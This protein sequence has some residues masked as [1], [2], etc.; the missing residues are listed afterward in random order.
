MAIKLDLTNWKETCLFIIQNV[1]SCREIRRDLGS[2]DCIGYTLN[3]PCLR[4]MTGEILSGAEHLFE[5]VDSVTYSDGKTFYRNGG[6]FH[7]IEAIEAIELLY[8]SINT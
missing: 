1:K 5:R 6:E 8:G 3:K 4:P 7:T 2:G